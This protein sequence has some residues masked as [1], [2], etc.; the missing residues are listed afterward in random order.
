MYKFDLFYQRKIIESL[1]KT[2]IVEKKIKN[3]LRKNIYK[4]KKLVNSKKSIDKN[5]EKFKKL[6]FKIKKTKLI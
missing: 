5:L 1:K 2:N 6:W 3:F 4:M